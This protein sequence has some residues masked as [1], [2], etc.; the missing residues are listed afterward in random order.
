[1]NQ[2]I[3]LAGICLLVSITV[4]CGGRPKLA[5]V[6]GQVLINGE[7]VEGIEV[8]YVPDP[9]FG[10]KGRFSKGITDEK[11]NFV[12]KY[13]DDSKQNGVSIGSCRVTLRDLI[14]AYTSRDEVPQP[15][16]ISQKYIDSNRTPLRRDVTGGIVNNHIFELVDSTE[17]ESG[18]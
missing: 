14:S 18:E 11:G 9:E 17:I 2:Q 1:M 10:N 8:C 4:G 3:V 6:K 16:R 5:E 12:L 15:P 13:D 7:P